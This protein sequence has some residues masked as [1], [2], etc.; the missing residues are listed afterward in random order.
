MFVYISATSTLLLEQMP[1][2]HISLA[3]AAIS[4]I[5][6][7]TGAVLFLLSRLMRE[8]E[9][10]PLYRAN[11]ALQIL[12]A[13]MCGVGITFASSKHHFSHTHPI[14][15]LIHKGGVHHDGFLAQAGASK[16]LEDAIMN[17][18]KRY[19]QHPPP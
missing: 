11:I 9:S 15:I 3:H 5:A 18:R 10:K 6:S 14:D 7:T 17:Y 19:R 8:E 12:F 16:T 1:F 13:V 4:L 2:P